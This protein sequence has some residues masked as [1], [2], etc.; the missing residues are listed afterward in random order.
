MEPMQIGVP[1]IIYETLEDILEASIRKLSTDIAKRL[2]VDPK[3]LIKELK[4]EK[5]KTYLFEDG[6]DVN[7]RCKS[8]VI[9]INIYIPCEHPIVY[10]KECC[11]DHLEKPIMPPQGAEIWI[12]IYY[13]T[14]T[15]YR[16]KKN[17]VYDLERVAFGRWNSE[18]Q[19]IEKIVVDQ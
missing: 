5:I 12:P 10:G 4:K 7:I 17:I 1:K 2:N 6:T 3:I 14:T 16:D 19:E 8:Y 13:G 18:K 11:I 15:Y 9:Y